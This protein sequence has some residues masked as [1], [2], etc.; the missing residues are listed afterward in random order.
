M[1]S[2]VKILSAMVLITSALLCSC[3]RDEVQ[4]DNLLVG[5][6]LFLDD[7]SA[8]KRIRL[9]ADG[10][11]QFINLIAG[12]V[13]MLS[14]EGIL[15]GSGWMKYLPDKRMLPENGKGWSLLPKKNLFGW[16][17]VRFPFKLEGG[18]YECWGRLVHEKGGLELW[19]SVGDPDD[20][21]W[22]RFRKKD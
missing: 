19:F 12:D 17:Y 18:D 14:Q 1:K 3:S 7:P 5:D 22:K 8:E 9:D 11:V 16:D 2:I 21:E 15:V 6:W 20:Y 4:S 13:G 10:S